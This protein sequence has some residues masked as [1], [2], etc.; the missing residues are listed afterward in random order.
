MSQNIKVINHT[1]NGF[2]SQC[3]RCKSFHIS[4]GNIFLDLTQKE[5]NHFKKFLSGLNPD[6][7][8]QVY[9][10]CAV[11]RKIP[12]PTLQ[13]NLQIMLNRSELEEL[14][15]LLGMTE[16]STSELITAEKVDYAVVLN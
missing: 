4:F 16:E 10:S 3:Q 9:C 14:K 2:F 6:H 11:K 7:W 1:R 5:L 12:I 15:L 13:T 8:E